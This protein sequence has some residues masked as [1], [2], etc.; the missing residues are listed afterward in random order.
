MQTGQYPACKG[1][2]CGCTDGRSH[3]P[4]CFA[5]HEATVNAA[6]LADHVEHGGWKCDFC[7]YNG[8]DNQ[9]YNQFCARCHVHR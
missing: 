4:E 6:E 5:E 2:D 8:Q 7:G 3:S 9:R 1:T